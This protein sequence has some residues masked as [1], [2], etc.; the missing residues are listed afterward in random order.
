MAKGVGL[1]CFVNVVARLCKPGQWNIL[2]DE[3]V[4]LLTLSQDI[5]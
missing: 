2:A 3:N 5:T 1:I 4:G